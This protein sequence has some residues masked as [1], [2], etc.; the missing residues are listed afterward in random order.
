MLTQYY[1]R[2][3]SSFMGATS[4]E[5]LTASEPL[6]GPYIASVRN[7]ALQHS[8]WLAVGGFPETVYNCSGLYTTQ[9]NHQH[10]YSSVGQ[11]SN[12]HKFSNESSSPPRK[13]YNT[14]V[15]IDPA[16]NI[17]SPIYRKMHLFDCPLVNLQESRTTG[18]TIC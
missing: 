4:D 10:I 15:L 1:Y 11:T 14:H 13:V 2:Q 5:L 16:G 12:G 7:L 3:Y 18:T 9:A 8:V 6:H 17:A